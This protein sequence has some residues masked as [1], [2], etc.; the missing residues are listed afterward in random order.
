[1]LVLR[2]RS[3]ARRGGGLPRGP[4]VRAGR[5]AQADGL[6]GLVD[7]V[8]R[9]YKDGNMTAL[10]DV[11]LK[12][13][14]RFDQP[15]WLNIADRVDSAETEEE[16]EVLRTLSGTLMTAVEQAM[17]QSEQM[18]EKSGALL[19]RIVNRGADP[20]T[21]EFSLP[22]SDEKLAEIGSA[23]EESFDE[24]DEST[25][26]TAYT[27]MEKAAKDGQDAI[28]LLL[29]HVLRTYAAV[30]LS[31]KASK[32]GDD[33][34][35]SML[36]ADP[37]TWVAEVRRAVESNEISEDGLKERLQATMEELLFSFPVGS[38]T[39]RLFAEYLKEFEDRS[40]QAFA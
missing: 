15:F 36:R 37:D 40:K 21:G 23:V 25:I 2:A 17:K 12:N 11:T 26:S 32:N 22:L 10:A 18:T 35:S 38:F 33:L 29:Q 1:M 27:I 8:V 28:V 31:T 16:K 13:I 30:A 34:L 4:R 6:D 5:A 7:E 20:D 3:A 19:E 24:I 39:Q 14:R 9:L